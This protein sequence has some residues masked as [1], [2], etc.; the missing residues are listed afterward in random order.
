MRVKAKK[1]E[2]PGKNARDLKTGRAFKSEFS[3]KF[4]SK[5]HTEMLEQPALLLDLSE[6]DESRRPPGSCQ[7][8]M[9]AIVDTLRVY[10]RDLRLIL[11]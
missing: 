1:L 10:A 8:S 7:K 11:W 6:S 4:I 2:P 3:E 9:S 5:G